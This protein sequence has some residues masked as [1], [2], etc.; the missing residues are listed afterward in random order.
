M[1]RII[2]LFVHF[3][4]P[5]GLN[6]DVPGDNAG[7]NRNF[8]VHSCSYNGQSAGRNVSKEGPSAAGRR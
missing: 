4:V 1:G 6:L 8:A 5:I 3:V 2:F 7:E